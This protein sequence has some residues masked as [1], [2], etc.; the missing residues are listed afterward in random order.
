MKDF[1]KL[2]DLNIPNYEYFDY[3][4]DQL[5]KSERFKDIKS[6]LK[7]YLDIKDNIEDFYEL[8]MSKSTD[9][10]E[11]IKT[12]NAYT[13]L[14]F[15]KNLLYNKT[16]RSI[17]YSEEQIYLSV[18][19][20]C[21]NWISL[22]NYDQQNELGDTYFDLL[23]KFE[24]TDVFIQSK[25]L[26]QFIFGNINQKKQQK[27]QRNIIQNEIVRK[28][29]EN[30]HIEAVKNDEVIFK[31]DNFKECEEIINSI[32]LERYSTKIFKIKRVE[33][34]RIDS[35]FDSSG[36]LI[37]KDM[38]GCNGTQFYL[39]LKQYITKEKLNIQDL[40]FKSDGKLAVWYVDGLNCQF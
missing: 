5:S 21:A 14:C 1:I 12:T 4:I 27:V 2:F 23:R 39:K 28:F 11:F 6:N 36:Y 13:E 33:D 19:L 32:N 7:L 8:K 31:L 34:F 15:D 29:D 26:R 18:D 35:I 10:V 40:Y 38:V 16:N 37:K 3:Y 22:K 25:Y 9:I 20:K 17:H 30:F 24:L